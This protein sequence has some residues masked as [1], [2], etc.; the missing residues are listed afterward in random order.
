MKK[1][2]FIM[3]IFFVLGIV[4]LVFFFDTML[5]VK[6]Q[7]FS[8]LSIPTSK[9]VNLIILFSLALILILS[10]LKIKSK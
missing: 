10:G 9:N 3:N 6:T 1:Y 8:F 7:N 5:S 2:K 4:C